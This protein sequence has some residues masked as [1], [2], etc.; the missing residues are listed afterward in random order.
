MSTQPTLPTGPCPRQPDRA[1]RPAV[2]ARITITDEMIEKGREAREEHYLRVSPVSCT[3]G[4]RSD[5]YIEADGLPRYE[6]HLVELALE[7]AAPLIASQALREATDLPN[8]VAALEALPVGTVIRIGTRA[9]VHTAAW[10]WVE[11]VTGTAYTAAELD[12]EA[13]IIYQPEEES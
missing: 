7:A 13:V 11:T 2:S 5:T 10:E 12:T 3:C 8:E 6:A 9:Y 4:W 1:G